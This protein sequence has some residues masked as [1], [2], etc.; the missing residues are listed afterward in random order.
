MLSFLYDLEVVERGIRLFLFRRLTI[1]VIEF[2]NIRCVTE[3]GRLTAFPIN[4]YNYKNRFG[5][6]TF[7]LALRRGWFA[8]L[9]LVTPKMPEAFLCAL[10]KHGVACDTQQG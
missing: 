6:R 10:R 5:A 4:A 2:D 8:Q 1:H 3:V 7:A 9:I